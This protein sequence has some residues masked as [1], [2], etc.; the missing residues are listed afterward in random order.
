ARQ[1]RSQPA[2][3]RS[4]ANVEAD[5]LVDYLHQAIDQ[6]DQTGRTSKGKP[7]DQASHGDQS[8]QGDRTSRG[9]Q[10]SQAKPA[11]QASQVGQ[12]SPVEPAAQV[13]RTLPVEAASQTVPTSRTLPVSQTLSA[14]SPQPGVT[15]SRAQPGET[16]D[17]VDLAAASVAAPIEVRPA[18]R[19][20]ATAR[21]ARLLVM[22]DADVLDATEAAA[23]T[24]IGSPPR[25]DPAFGPVAPGRLTS[26]STSRLLVKIGPAQLDPA[27]PPGPGPGP[28]PPGA[29]PVRLE[30]EI[31]TGDSG[32]PVGKGPASPDR[33]DPPGLG[34]GEVSSGFAVPPDGK[35]LAN[36]PGNQQLASHPSPG[37]MAGP[38]GGPAASS[39]TGLMV[40]SGSVVTGP[41]LDGLV[42]LAHRQAMVI[43]SAS[44]R[45]V[46]LGPRPSRPGGKLI[47]PK[48]TWNW[49]D[50]ATWPA[51]RAWSDSRLPSGW[52]ALMLMIRDQT[53]RWPGCIVP[54]TDCQFDHLEP[55][56]LFRESRAQ[57]WA[58]NLVC[59][60][61]MHHRLRHDQD[62]T[63]RRDPT[64]GQTIWTG[65]HG[66]TLTKPPERF[67]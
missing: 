61:L 49:K 65:P 24:V 56:S 32:P 64:T 15:V 35:R 27:H 52:L 11:G 40:G 26:T 57:T 60:C 7:V 58:G 50:P 44:G 66:Q 14:V 6:A 54:A 34:D 5:L 41:D 42:A 1:A 37:A 9:D 18:V 55:F 20:R 38:S 4:L 62:W 17:P 63:G 3:G 19:Q 45:L 43:D 12:I 8:S 59:V 21:N 30:S 51:E 25:A 53:C 16:A 48:V 31:R 10:A 23:G 2:A 46:A 13:F 22:V 28:R 39:S 29:D 36:S 47:P 67:D 33:A